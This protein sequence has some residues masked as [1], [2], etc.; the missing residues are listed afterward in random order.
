MVERGGLEN[1]CGTLFHREFESHSLR[2]I[3]CFLFIYLMNGMQEEH[4]YKAREIFLS[5][6]IV[7]S[8]Y[9]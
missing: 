2:K 4:Y 3:K 6:M 9:T 1:R 8:A 5:K 7:M